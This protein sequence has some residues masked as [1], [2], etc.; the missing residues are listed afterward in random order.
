MGDAGLQES[1]LAHALIDLTRAPMITANADAV[2]DLAEICQSAFARPVSVSITFGDPTAPTLVATRSKVAQGLDGA[3]VIAG[4]GPSLESWHRGAVVHTAD[5]RR[6]GR[7]PRLV[8]RLG[9]SAVCGAMSVPIGA[10]DGEA[11][12]TLN[13]YSV[14]A[15]LVDEAALESV[16]LLAVSIGDVLHRA[17]ERHGLEAAARQLENALRSRATIDQAKGILMARHG[18]TADEAF[19]MLAEASSSANVKLRE[20]AQRLVDE[21]AGGPGQHD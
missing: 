20:L 19:R 7:W 21:T 18:C 4:E 8:L 3:Q 12:G 11:V 17:R 15:D 10:P 16:E 14:F 1:R 6:D 13:V 2:C 9:S 5:L